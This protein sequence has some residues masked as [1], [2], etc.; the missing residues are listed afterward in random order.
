MTSSAMA[1]SE[2]LTTSAPK[3]AAWLGHIRRPDD[4]V[5]QHQIYNATPAAFASAR[6]AWT[7]GGGYETEIHQHV[8]QIIAFSATFGLRACWWISVFVT[9]PQVQALRAEAN[10]AGV[11]RVDLM[12]ANKII[13]PADVTQA[14]SRAFRR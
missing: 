8:H 9:A 7:C 3:C 12:L 1:T 2:R 4:F 5:G 14:K 6:S 13:R 10:A 11:W